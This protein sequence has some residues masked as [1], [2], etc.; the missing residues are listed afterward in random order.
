M[1]GSPR[2]AEMVVNALKSLSIAAVLHPEVSAALDA[3]Q[4]DA[5]AEIRR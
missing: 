3:A 5:A 4:R 1:R 2:F